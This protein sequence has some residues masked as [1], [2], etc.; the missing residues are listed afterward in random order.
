MCIYNVL[1]YYRELSAAGIIGCHSN[2]YIYNVLLYYRGLSAAG[3]AGVTIAI[4]VYTMCCYITEA[5]VLQVLLV[6]Q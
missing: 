1:L 4:G 6:L 5:S 3:M 2:R